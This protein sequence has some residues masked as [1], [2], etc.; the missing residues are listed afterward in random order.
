MYKYVKANESS[1]VKLSLQY[2]PYDRYESSGIKKATISAPTLRD[3]LIK[4]TDNLQL[5]LYPEDIEDDDMSVEEIIDS[6]VMSNGDGCD[7]ILELKNLTTGETLISANYE[8]YP[9]EW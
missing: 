4:L 3:A 5:Y 8:E 7:F 9:E 1:K 2:E 6:I